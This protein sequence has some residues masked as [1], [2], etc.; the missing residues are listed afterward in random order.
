MLGLRDHKEK[1]ALQVQM[2]RRA[3]PVSPESVDLSDRG[4]LTVRQ[5]QKAIRALRAA[6]EPQD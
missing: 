6:Q 2:E 1:T 5:A 4:G 3:R